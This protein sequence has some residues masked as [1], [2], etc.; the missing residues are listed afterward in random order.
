MDKPVWDQIYKDYQKGGKAWATLEGGLDE[1]FKVFIEKTQFNK[2]SAFD[3]GYGTGQYLKYL[4]LNG[5]EISGVDSS[6]T[7]HEMASK[8]LG[9]NRELKVANMYE[10]NIPKG[11]YDLIFSI[12]TIHHGRKSQINN[13]LEKIHAALTDGSY[14]YITLPVNDS[15][16]EWMTFKDKDQLEPGTYAPNSGPEK[17]L[18]HSFY[19]KQEVR[20]LF[21]IYSNALVAEDNRG[22]WIIIAQK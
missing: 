20:D 4:K 18:P 21:S 17:G 14:I 13:L 12:S 16:N 2:K 1:S 9:I 10:T 15:S 3:I 8:E 5:F 22:R 6:L 7:A 11:K 19:N